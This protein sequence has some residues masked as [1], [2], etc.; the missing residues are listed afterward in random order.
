MLLVS[1]CYRWGCCMQLTE[2]TQ[3]A[4][5]DCDVRE[6][7]RAVSRSK[8]APYKLAGSWALGTQPKRWQVQTVDGRGAGLLVAWL[9]VREM[10]VEW[11][12]IREPAEGEDTS[13]V[14]NHD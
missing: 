1:V 13:D 11:E 2:T 3:R 4:R 6:Y 7:M 10:L 14:I 8:E 9:N 12:I 5:F